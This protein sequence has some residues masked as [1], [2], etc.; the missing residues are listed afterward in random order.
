MEIPLFNANSV[1][2]DPPHSLASDLGLHSLSITSLGDHQTEV[3]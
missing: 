3:G 2:P 1:D